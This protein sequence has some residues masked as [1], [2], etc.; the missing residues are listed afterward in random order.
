MTTATTGT[1]SSSANQVR[2]YPDHGMISLTRDQLKSAPDF[3]YASEASRDTG[4]RG[5]AR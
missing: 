5:T 4:S 2:D 1:G 3:R